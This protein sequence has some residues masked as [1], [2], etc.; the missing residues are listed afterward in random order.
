MCGV[1]V[2]RCIRGMSRIPTSLVFHLLLE[3]LEARHFAAPQTTGPTNWALFDFPANEL[4]ID[5]S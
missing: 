4:L 2:N 3:V 5:F 1:M